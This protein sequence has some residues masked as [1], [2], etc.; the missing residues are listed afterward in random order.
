ML[1]G[2]TVYSRTTDLYSFVCVTIFII[3]W[4]VRL[5][6]RYRDRNILPHAPFLL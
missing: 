1:G 2:I 5:P 4:H 3:S 6:G